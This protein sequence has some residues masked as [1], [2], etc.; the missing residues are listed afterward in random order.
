MSS[1]RPTPPKK[2]DCDTEIGLEMLATI[3]RKAALEAEFKRLEDEARQRQEK[4]EEA[5]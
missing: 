5:P 2:L 3:F 4:G 1:S